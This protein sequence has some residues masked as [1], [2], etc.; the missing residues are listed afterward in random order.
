[1]SIIDQVI[2]AARAQLG[3]PYVFGQ[4]GPDAF[5]CSG[6]TAYSYA[7]GGISLPHSAAQ[8]QAMTTTVTTPLPGD[9]VF[10]GQPAHH[11]GL[12]LGGGRMIAAPHAGAVVQ[13]QDVYGS[14][15]YGRVP[16]AGTAFAPAIATATGL[17]DGISD[18]I[19]SLED[20]VK[21]GIFVLLG[22]A[23]VGVG[24]WRMVSAPA[25]AAVGRMT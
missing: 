21:S 7:A 19:R 24:M 25:R 6:L 3:D 2:A 20:N 23:L 22:V 8:Q 9:L 4:Q 18:A 14:P 12:Y 17:G 13:I 16:G 5:D 11:V 10:Y 1:V 15:T